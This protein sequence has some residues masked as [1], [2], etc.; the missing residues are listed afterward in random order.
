[1]KITEISR[2][3]SGQNYDNLRATAQLVDEDDPIK[4]ML[5]LDQILKMALDEIE[6]REAIDPPILYGRSMEVAGG[7]REDDIPS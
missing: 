5:E 6:R 4:A 2:T 3:V 1:M 7:D